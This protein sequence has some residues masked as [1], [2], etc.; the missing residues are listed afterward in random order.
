MFEDAR[1]L[2]LFLLQPC[3]L[4]SEAHSSRVIFLF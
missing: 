4:E 1:A 2:L 3:C